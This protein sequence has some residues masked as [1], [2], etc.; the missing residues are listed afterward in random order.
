MADEMRPEYDLTGGV[1]GKYYDAY[2]APTTGGG[3]PYAWM[4]PPESPSQFMT[5]LQITTNTQTV[6]WSP[7]T[8]ETIW[9]P[10]GAEPSWKRGVWA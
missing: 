3:I 7:L 8:P 10:S 6:A 1:R 9:L 5:N 4:S 2:H